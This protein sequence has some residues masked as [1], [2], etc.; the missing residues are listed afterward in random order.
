M[1]KEILSIIGQLSVK[2]RILKAVQSANTEVGELKDREILILELL[3]TQG[4]ISVSE[5]CRFF[6]GVAQS[7]ISNDIKNLRTSKGFIEK[8]FGDKDERVHM[9]ELTPKGFEKVN[10]VKEKRIKLYIPLKDAIGEDKKE[11]ALLRRIV[12]TAIK[13]V[14]NELSR[15]G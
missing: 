6:P 13:K 9:I 5:L 14:D 7:T 10:E 15:I 12:T 3:A 11:I 4:A 8:R 2:M 1:K